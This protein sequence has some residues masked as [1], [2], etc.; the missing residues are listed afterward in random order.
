M[1]TSLSNLNKR[2]ATDSKSYSNRPFY[3]FLSLFYG[4]ITLFIIA[5]TL[6]KVGVL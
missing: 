6:I 5:L 4:Y 1:K 3:L 2:S